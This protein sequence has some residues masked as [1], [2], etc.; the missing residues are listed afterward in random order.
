[1]RRKE[2]E[3]RALRRHYLDGERVWGFES[4]EKTQDEN[5]LVMK[6]LARG[7]GMH[8]QKSY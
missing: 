8:D 1:M 5:K 6:A 4:A 7:M 3:K 2:P